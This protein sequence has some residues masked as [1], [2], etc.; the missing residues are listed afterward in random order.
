MDKWRCSVCGH[1]HIN[2]R[3]PFKC[4]VC[5]ADKNAIYEFKTGRS[6]RDESDPDTD[7][8]QY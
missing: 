8:T 3:P 5:R 6:E 2:P 4:P 1:I 7:E